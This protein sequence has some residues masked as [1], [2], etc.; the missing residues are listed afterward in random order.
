MVKMNKFLGKNYQ[1]E[2]KKLHFDVQFFPMGGGYSE[3]Y[4]PLDIHLQKK[5]LEVTLATFL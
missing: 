2:R 3:K 4:T 5:G 1:V